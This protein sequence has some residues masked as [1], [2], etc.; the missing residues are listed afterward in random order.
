[1]II[2]WGTLGISTTVLLEATLSYLGVGVQPPTPSWGN[3]IFENQTYFQSAPWLVFFPGAAIVVLALAFNLRG[4]RAARRARPDAEGVGLMTAYL[5][6]RLI[7]SALIL[8]GVSFITFFL[9][10][11]PA[12]RPGAP[13]RRAVGHAADGGQHPRAAGPRSAVRGAVLVAISTG[14]FQGDMGRSYL[15]KTDVATLI[16]ARLPASLLLMAAGIA[17][18]LVIGLTMGV[19]AALWR[20]R[21]VDNGADDDLASSPSSAP[22]FVVGAAAALRLRGEARLVPHRRLRHRRASRAAGDDARDPRVGLVRADDAV[23]HGRGAARRFRPHRPR[24]GTDPRAASSCATPCRTR[25]CRSS[26]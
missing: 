8:L 5:I 26:R 1:M 12:R 25:S 14:L 20:G 24:Q 9:L 19:V 11:V 18:E 17:A 23:Q 2:V 21:R 22:Q 13:D 10:Y 15:Q 7:Q 16:M 4:R 6:R 3:I